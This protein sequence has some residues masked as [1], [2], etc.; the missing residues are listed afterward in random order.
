MFERTRYD[1]TRGSD[2]AELDAIWRS[3]G[4]SIRKVFKEEW[5]PEIKEAVRLGHMKV[6]LCLGYPLTSS[7]QAK[8]RFKALISHGMSFL[9]AQGFDVSTF[10]DSDDMDRERTHLIISWE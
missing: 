7:R 10:V 6:M 2:Q 9:Q 3:V 4:F 8:T 1:F 5:L